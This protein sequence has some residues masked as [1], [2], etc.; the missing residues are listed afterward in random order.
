M[1]KSEI[2][3]EI[4]K[5]GD[6]NIFTLL[7]NKNSVSK[8]YHLSNG[9]SFTLKAEFREKKNSYW[10]E[11][12]NINGDIKEFCF[13][14][15]PKSVYICPESM[16]KYECMVLTNKSVIELNFNVYFDLMHKPSSP[17]SSNSAHNIL[18]KHGLFRSIAYDEYLEFYIRQSGKEKVYCIIR[19]VFILNDPKP[20]YFIYFNWNNKNGSKNIFISQET[21]SEKFTIQAKEEMNELEAVCLKMLK[22]AIAGSSTR[23]TSTG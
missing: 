16:Y 14:D 15:T 13:V 4:P 19:K 9:S 10:F 3:K 12:T 8:E 23:K 21:N 20:S 5:F 7:T 11:I 1:M 17:N 6:N 2:E 18:F 22:D